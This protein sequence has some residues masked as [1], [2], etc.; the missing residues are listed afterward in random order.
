MGR[1]RAPFIF[2]T[3]GLLALASFS[4]NGQREDGSTYHVERVG[5][6][7]VDVGVSQDLIRTD[8]RNAAAHRRTASVRSDGVT[9]SGTATRWA[10]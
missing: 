6:P 3:V 7:A 8:T 4:V 9:A 2:L 10:G 1:S 5:L